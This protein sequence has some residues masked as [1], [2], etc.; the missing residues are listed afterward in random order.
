MS[1][2]KVKIGD[3]LKRS[4]IPINIEDGKSYKRVTIRTKHQGVSLRDE[5]M[6]KKIG[7]KKQFVLKQ[8]QFVLSK[9]DARYGA[10]GIAPEETDGA[11]ITGNFWAY[12]VDKSMMNI[13]WFNQYTNSPVFYDI[14]E[15]ASSGI[16]HRKYLNEDFFLNHE[17]MIPDIDEQ[18]SH[19]KIIQN[20]KEVFG[21]LDYS[22]SHQ[23]DLLK[24]LRQQI[25][26][27]AVQGKLV[28]Q[29][30]NDEPASKLLERIKAEKEKLVREK[31]IKKSKPLPPI[32]SEEIPFEI[33]ENWVWCRLG[34]IGVINPRNYI[35][36]DKDVSFIPMSF[37][38]EKY[39][40]LP[41]FEKRKWRDIKRGFTH[42]ANNDVAV[43]KITPC[44][45]NSKACVF[46]NLLNGY[47]AGTTELH[48]FRGISDFTLP[49]YIYLNLKT[50]RFLINGERIMRGVAGQKRVPTEYFREF[51]IP[52]PP[53]QE[54]HRIVAKIDQLMTLCDELEQSIKQSQ[55]YTQ[56]LLQV[57]L[58]EALEPK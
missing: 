23:L 42:F 31:K 48:V 17:L 12:D 9:I 54:Q 20:L 36:D 4:K 38:Y 19:V 44:F 1:W 47:G 53:L 37:I 25:L 16:T 27:D 14:C 15:R 40:E 7:T 41:D 2:H 49:D 39:G 58:K 45:E 50:N 51:F 26:Q 43:A 56:E 10:F 57:A 18:D 24:K 11:I 52:L 28:P 29:D 34:E 35:S 3:F 32:N 30:P 8:G 22:L 13:D 33:P 21:N 46:K 5:E 6:G 55:K